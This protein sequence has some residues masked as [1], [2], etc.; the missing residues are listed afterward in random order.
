VCLGSA[1]FFIKWN[2]ANAVASR[3]DIERKESLT[4]ADWLTTLS[5]GDPQTHY[6]A[7]VL[8]DKTFNPADLARSV[9]E[10]EMAAA[11]SPNNYL[12]W[13]DVGKARNTSG[14]REGAEAA[15]RRALDLAPN[16]S[17]VQWA[18]GNFLVRQGRVDEGFSLIARAAASN[19]SYSIPAVQIAFQM[20][21]GDLT[22]IKASLG[23]SDV[24]TAAMANVLVKASRFQESFDAWSGIRDKSNFKALGDELVNEM[25]AGKQYRLAARVASDVAPEDADK[26]TVG[27]ISNG[28]FESGV[29]QRGAGLFE[30]KIA[31]GAEPQI[32]L[33]DGQKRSG[34][35]SLFLVFN[36]FETAAFRQ[37]SQIAP[38]V[39]GATYEFEVFYRADLK[40]AALLKWEIGDAS[41]AAIAITPAVT[42]TNE[43]TPLRVRF[44]VP[45][46]SDAIQVR[47]V[48]EGCSGPSCPMT[49]RISFDDLSLKPV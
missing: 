16:Y 4:V 25:A 17:A 37:V 30:W 26:P 24:T 48:R 6:A 49:G 39:P 36:S 3:L 41:T 15:F 28:G 7:A 38:V 18:Y 14:D 46:T 29:K 11:L 21:D 44:T 31:E 13:L 5:P 19:P 8:F 23:E 43:W 12:T 2:F 42:Q 22:A 40:T 27:Q 20:L 1:W 34:R 45:I 10:Y 33:S 35:Y 9:R 47:L 32:G